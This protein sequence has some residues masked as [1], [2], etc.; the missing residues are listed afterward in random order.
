[1]KPR[2]KKIFYSFILAVYVTINL[3]SVFHF[4]PIK[5]SPV[6]YS[7]LNE[8]KRGVPFDPF[9]DSDSKCQL[10]QFSQITYLESLPQNHNDIAHFSEIKFLDIS[11]NHFN[12]FEGWSSNLRAPPSYS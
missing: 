7:I 1:M 8:S 10:L 6:D 5:Y 11:T 12:A 4:H 3:L 2:T 9:L